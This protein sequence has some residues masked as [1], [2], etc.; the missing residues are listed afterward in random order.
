MME[1]VMEPINWV[2]SKASGLNE[3]YKE[4]NGPQYVKL[5]LTYMQVCAY[6]KHSLCVH[7][8]DVPVL[9]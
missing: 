2:I 8:V 3:W 4:Q 1:K 9:R 7:E 6:E 5:L